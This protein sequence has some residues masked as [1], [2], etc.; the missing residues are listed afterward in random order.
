[1]TNIIENMRLATI[2]HQIV[3]AR[4]R[5]ER[6]SLALCVP[7][8][9]IFNYHRLERSSKYNL[10]PVRANNELVI[11]DVYINNMSSKL[12]TF[13][14]RSLWLSTHFSNAFSQWSC[15]LLA[16]STAS[17]RYS[18]RSRYVKDYTNIRKKFCLLVNVTFVTQ[19]KR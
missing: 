7:Y 4:I 16:D 5:R 8:Y 15:Y 12:F 17:L 6:F 13:S 3:Y 2:L 10:S 19:Y 11:V 18:S 9:T 14:V 1:M